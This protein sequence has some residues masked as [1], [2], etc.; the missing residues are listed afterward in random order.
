M[1][2]EWKSR[3]VVCPQ[4]NALVQASSLRRHLAEQHN[5]Y[6][7]VVVPEDYLVPQAG[8]R[9]QAHPGRNG[10]IPCPAQGCSGEL[11]DGWM[12]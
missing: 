3:M 7:A 6:Q 5:T 12:L 10:K 1:A 9:Y 4:C 11:R 8:V 2:G